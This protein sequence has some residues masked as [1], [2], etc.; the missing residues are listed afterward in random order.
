MALVG[1]G[2]IHIW[3]GRL[4][5]DLAKL[6]KKFCFLDSFFNIGKILLQASTSCTKI[7]ILESEEGAELFWVVCLNYP[8]MGVSFRAI[9][10]GTSS[11][12]QIHTNMTVRK[13]VTGP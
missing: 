10:A 11:G 13:G 2:T 9:R 7:Y 1:Y 8:D 5:C 6:R 3:V 4:Q 12:M